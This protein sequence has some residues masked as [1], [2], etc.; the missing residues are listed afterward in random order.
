MMSI[1]HYGLD[2]PNAVLKTF[3]CGQGDARE[4]GW[5]NGWRKRS[6]YHKVDKRAIAEFAN[7]EIATS[8]NLAEFIGE[9]GNSGSSYIGRV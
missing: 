3:V 4:E 2:L 8:K 7:R 9:G 1:H 6:G 5:R